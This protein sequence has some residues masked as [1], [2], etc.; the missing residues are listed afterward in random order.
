MPYTVATASSICRSS[1]VILSVLLI[2]SPPTDSSSRA[3]AAESCGAARVP[4]VGDV[5]LSV[6][7]V[8]AI[9]AALDFARADGL[10][11]GGSPGEEIVF[12]FFIFERAVE[13]VLDL[14][15]ALG[16]DG[17]G[18]LRDLVA[19]EEANLV[20][21]LP[22]AV[23]GQERADLEVAGGDV[24]GLGKIAPVAQIAKDFPVV[25]AVIDDEQFAAGFAGALRHRLP[26]GVTRRPVECPRA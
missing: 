17:A 26:A 13:P 16:E 2:A 18:A 10:D 22:L 5:R 21:L 1:V 14:G 9:D 15:Q 11:Y 6:E 25:V 23:E 24:D 20:E 3:C 12:L 4:F 19:H 7:L 8:F